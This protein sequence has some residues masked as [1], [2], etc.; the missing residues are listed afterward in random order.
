MRR[1]FPRQSDV[2]KAPGPSRSSRFRK[3]VH[4]TRATRESHGSTAN[5]SGSGMPTSSHASGP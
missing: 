5:V 2:R 1:R 3:H 4:Q